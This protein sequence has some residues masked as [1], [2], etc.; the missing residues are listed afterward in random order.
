MAESTRS[1]PRAM[2]KCETIGE[3]PSAADSSFART[4]SVCRTI[5]FLVCF[6]RAGAVLMLGSLLWKSQKSYL[7][8][9]P[10][11]EG[12]GE[13]LSGNRLRLLFREA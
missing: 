13:G 2:S 12:Y 10:L 4:G 1:C 11:G 5:H 9:L 6:C 8:P 7:F 3:T